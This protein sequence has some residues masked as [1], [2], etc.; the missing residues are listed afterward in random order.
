MNAYVLSLSECRDA[1]QVGGKGINLGRLVQAGFPVP[2]GFVVTTESYRAGRAV[3]GTLPTVIA[4]EIAEAYRRMG[5][6]S[7]AVRSSA[8][9]ED[10]AGA[11]M[12]GQYE[13]YLDVQG[14]AAVLA[15]V[16]A[17]WA[18]L[19]SD[20]VSAYLTRNGIDPAAV[21][22][23]VVVQRLVP[24]DVAGVLFTVNVRN[25][26]RDEV[27]VE[28][29]WGLGESVVSGAVQPDTLVLDRADGRVVESVIG[30]K[31]TAIMPGNH[32]V[33]PVD[34]ARRAVACLDA[35]AVDNLWQ[36][37]QR[38]ERYFGSPQDLEWA[39]HAG[40]LFLLQ[41][42]AVTT[43]DDAEAP[44]LAVERARATCRTGLNA[45]Q[46]GWVRHNLGETLPQP[47]ALTWHVVRRFMSGSGGYG[48]LFRQVG[49]LPGPVA[50]AEGFLDL[51]G[52]RIYMDVGRGPEMFLAGFPYSYDVAML[53]ANPDAAQKPPSLSRATDVSALAAGRALAAVPALI[54]TAE[55]NFA[56]LLTG[57]TIPAYKAWVEVERAR[58]LTAL[59]AA[60]LLALFDERERRVLD[61]FGP[62]SLLPSVIGVQALDR[63]AGILRTWVW[64]QDP[65]ALAATI[66]A[67]HEPDLTQRANQQ[68]WAVA[69]GRLSAEAWLAEHGHRAIEEMELMVPRWRERPAALIA[70]AAQL[71]GGVD[72]AAAH[73]RRVDASKQ[74]TAA[75]RALIPAAHH[76]EF[77]QTVN[78]CRQALRWREDGKW[79][80]MYGYQLLRD[81]VVE[82]GRRLRIGDEV[83]LLTR[84]ELAAALTTGF[85]PRR[86]LAQRRRERVADKALV[87]PAVIE[88]QDLAGLGVPP[89]L[90]TSGTITAFALSPGRAAG[91]VRIVAS[92]ES[93]GDMGRGY[94][95]VC[96]STDPAW[97]PLFVNAAALVLECG[98]SLSHGAVVAREMGIPAVVVPGACR[99]LNEGELVTVD[100]VHGGLVRGSAPVEAMAVVATADDVRIPA[101][102]LPP[103]PGP[104]CRRIGFWRNVFAVLWSVWVI[105]LSLV[106]WG[107]MFGILWQGTWIDTITRVPTFAVGD[108][109]FTDLHASL[110]GPGLVTLVAAVVGAGLLVLQALL[111]DNRR[112]RTAN[113]RCA[114]LQA[115]ASTLPVDSPRAKAL[116]QACAGVQGRII[117]AAMVP[118]GLLLGPIM[119]PFLWFAERVDPLFGHAH[120]ANVTSVFVS[121]AVNGEFTGNVTLVPGAGW[122][123]D[124]DRGAEATQSLPP[125]RATLA[126]L[127]TQWSAANDLAALSWEV[128]AAAGQ[129]RGVMLADLD[130]FVKQPLAERVLKWVVTAPTSDGD[131]FLT[132]RVDG[133]PDQILRVPF[134]A[135]SNGVL[136]IASGEALLGPAVGA[137][138]P[139]KHPVQRWY[140][141]IS[142][143]SKRAETYPFFRPFQFL[144]W[145]WDAGWLIVYL[146]VYLPVMFLTKRVLRVP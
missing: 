103:G 25:G 104:I 20:R 16:E 67:P 94:V 106:M 72:P 134:G 91:P 65:E 129:A 80:L 45:G 82:C 118:L 31:A 131:H 30:S 9:A 40:E 12:A 84:A 120:A 83:C 133:Q 15:K 4:A 55:G 5:S 63:L 71:K 53:R 44:R 126:R 122:V 14:E 144:G 108:A 10:L 135:G 138:P 139:A 38:V 143:A 50:D 124:T 7:V 123:L 136:K 66:G 125:I 26:R 75:A 130:A 76:A 47:T 96:T 111:T 68:L 117:G 79:W 89:P 51:I 59:D 102:R 128:Q 21:L 41:S 95:L 137:F 85:A 121:A 141:A 52:G 127:R 99:L 27:L 46:G 57:T 17:C 110:G 145:G 6:P 92:P 32:A 49:F 119:I 64:D 61:E 34:A 73:H 35:D 18:S 56:Q 8:T 97:T 62:A 116:R 86:L 48:A 24:A 1:A 11:S 13:T 36:L 74:R 28:A 115:E 98:G 23:A 58:D 87:L 60:A 2:G 114:A 132:L 100:G 54:A 140:L 39:I 142:E 101:N 69:E 42:R 112:L 93:A 113:E 88:A 22:M 37:G 29:S 33:V 107:E 105:A 3:G 109:L 43:I 81:I 146:A 77:D 78:A 70:Y 90:P 19:R